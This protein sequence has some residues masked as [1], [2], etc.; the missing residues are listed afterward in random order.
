MASPPGRSGKKGSRYS[1]GVSAVSLKGDT[2]AGL[3]VENGYCW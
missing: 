1:Y 2:Y 3:S